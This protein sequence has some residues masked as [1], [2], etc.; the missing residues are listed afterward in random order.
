MI[1]YDNRSIK[2]SGKTW[3]LTPE[4]IINIFTFIEQVVSNQQV[5]RI[6]ECAQVVNERFTDPQENKCA[7]FECG[8]LIGALKMLAHLQV[9]CGNLAGALQPIIY[10]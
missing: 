7:L 2:Q 1:F 9:E 10:N 6:G 5:T 8:K 4:T 3:G